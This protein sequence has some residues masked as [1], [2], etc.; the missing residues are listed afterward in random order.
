MYIDVTEFGNRHFA[1]SFRH[2]SKTLMGLAGKPAKNHKRL[3]QGIDAE[4]AFT[5]I[6]L[7]FFTYYLVEKLFGGKQHLGMSDER[8]VAQLIRIFTQGVGPDGNHRSRL[9]SGGNRL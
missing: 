1:H 6:Y 3:P 5:S 9:N 7:Q 4:L 8:A 2:L